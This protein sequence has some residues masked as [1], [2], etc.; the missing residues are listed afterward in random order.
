MHHFLGYVLNQTDFFRG[1]GGR[2][3]IYEGRTFQYLMFLILRK[4][5]QNQ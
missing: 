4:K 2:G 5:V 3:T 1:G